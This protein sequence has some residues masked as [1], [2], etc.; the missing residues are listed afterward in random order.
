MNNTINKMV[1]IVQQS[2]K[3]VDNILSFEFS[4]DYTEMGNSIQVIKNVIADLEEYISS[5]FE[6]ILK[7]DGWESSYQRAFD[8]HIN[9]E[10]KEFIK[11]IIKDCNKFVS[12][13]EKTLSAYKKIDRY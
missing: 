10:T 2:T 13:L 1:E 7:H 12:Y 8:N 5:E 6:F 11:A 9:S 3:L 4:V